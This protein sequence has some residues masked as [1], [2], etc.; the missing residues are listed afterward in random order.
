MTII[1]KENPDKYVGFCGV[2]YGSGFLSGPTIGSI[3][4]TLTDYTKTFILF[5]FFIISG[6]IALYFLVPKQV[7]KLKKDGHDEANTT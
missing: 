2:A 1:F 3:I 7:N 6:A 5:G 4:Y